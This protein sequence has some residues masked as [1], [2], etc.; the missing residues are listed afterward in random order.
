MGAMAAMHLAWE[1][2]DVAGLILQAPM[3]D[4]ETAVLAYQ[5]SYASGW[6]RLL[7]RGELKRGIAA[8]LERVNLDE[9]QLDLRE[10]LSHSPLPTLVLASDSDPFSPYERLRTLQGDR[11]QVA[12]LGGQGHMQM[13]TMD[14]GKHRI[15][16]EWMRRQLPKFMPPQLQVET[17]RATP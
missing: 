2:E 10:L 11:V 13:W 16:S 3:V 17:D 1:R 15:V 5:H 9:K 4:L 14:P 6:M 8:A 12:N 7:P